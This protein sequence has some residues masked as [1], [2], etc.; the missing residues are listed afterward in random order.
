MKKQEKKKLVLNKRKIANLSN[1]ELSNLYGGNAA[2]QKISIYT[3]AIS[4][5]PRTTSNRC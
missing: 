4:I 1:D 2:P 3:S 5:N